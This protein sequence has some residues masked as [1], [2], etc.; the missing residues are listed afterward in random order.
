MIRIDFNRL[1]ILVVDDGTRDVYEAEDGACAEAGLARLSEFPDWMNDECDRLDQARKS[2][3]T[4]G[5]AVLQRE[6]LFRASHDM[7]G[8]AATLGFPLVAAV[9]AS[10]CRLIEETADPRRIPLVLIDQHV[11]AVRAVN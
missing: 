8:Q 1:R 2:V 5:M 3:K 11:D 7:K 10:L 9:A 4:T 6:A